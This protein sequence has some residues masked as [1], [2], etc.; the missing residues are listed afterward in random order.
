MNTTEVEIKLQVTDETTWG[1]IVAY[2]KNMPELVSCQRLA[3]AANYFDT[4]DGS[5]H[6]EQLAYRVRKEN[7]EWVATIK[8]RGEVVNGLHRRF[9]WNVPVENGSPNLSVFGHIAIDQDLLQKIAK[10][11]LI[12]IVQTEFIREVC[13]VKWAGSEIEIALD[14]GEI[15]ANSKKVP[16]LEIELEIKNGKKERR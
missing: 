14:R 8:G 16:I 5:L 10:A 6:K 9:E 12:P 1:S 2:V 7:T 13:L 15:I 4:I 3:L 11:K